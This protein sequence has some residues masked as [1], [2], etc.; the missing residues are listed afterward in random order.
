V[1]EA[2]GE[3]VNL[4]MIADTDPIVIEAK[5]GHTYYTGTNQTGNTGYFGVRFSVPAPICARVRLLING[6]YLPKGTELRLNDESR[7]VLEGGE[8]S[9]QLLTDTD[10]VT[11]CN[12][13][14]KVYRAVLSIDENGAY[15]GELSLRA[16]A[17]NVSL[18]LSG[19]KPL[20]NIVL[21]SVGGKHNTVVTRYKA[22]LDEACT[23]RFELLPY[24]SYDLTAIGYELESERVDINEANSDIELRAY[25]WECATLPK[26]AKVGDGKLYVGYKASTSYSDRIYYSVQEAVDAA[27]EDAEIIIAPNVYT[28]QVNIN[29]RLTL[30]GNPEGACNGHGD[31]KAVISYYDGAKGNNERAVDSE[32]EDARFHGDT[33]TVT[34][35]R[36]TA[37]NIRVE[38]ISELRFGKA[39]ADNATAISAGLTGV[40]SYI[41]LNECEIFGY[42]DTI[43]T[44]KVDRNIRWRLCQCKIY[45]FQDV[46]CGGGDVELDR[47]EWI[48]NADS[49]ARL[50][51]PQASPYR[52]T[53]MYADSLV[54]DTDVEGGL[55]SN[56]YLGRGWGYIGA[57]LAES[58]QVIVDGYT[59]RTG[60]VHIDDDY[61]G[62][63]K[64]LAYR[65]SEKDALFNA[66]WHVRADKRDKLKSTK[67]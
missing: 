51:V 66:S 50:F 4:G 23:A 33:M 65:G 45:G 25:V 14:G 37:Y 26:T 64:S 2:S 15:S 27:E 11:E 32:D 67:K 38:N 24:G 60:R 53:R 36:L 44:G 3:L 35:G 55:T 59:D 57:Y 56:V 7:R 16:V 41:E 12:R 22:T 8:L 18:R 6:E 40:D 62:F 54:I 28:E 34:G 31:T 58:T 17:G 5:A 61:K 9:A 20:T 47:C 13:D 52:V 30:I 19:C 46:I 21:E 49:D 29:K 1:D 10:Y 42:R 48:V 39:A 43:Y 63:D